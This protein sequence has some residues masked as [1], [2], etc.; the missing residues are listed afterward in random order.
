M[1]TSRIL[2]TASAAAI[3]ATG[4][5]GVSVAKASECAPA[6]VE[7]AFATNTQPMPCISQDLMYVV[8]PVSTSRNRLRPRRSSTQG[9]QIVRRVKSAARSRQAVASAAFRADLPTQPPKIHLA[10][11]KHKSHWGYRSSKGPAKWSTL[12]EKFRLCGVGRQQSPIDIAAA[13]EGTSSSISFD[14][15]GGPATVINNGHTV[16]VNVPRG[17]RLRVGDRVYRLI[18][19]HFHTPSENTIDGLHYPME[20]HLV[21]KDANG[22]LAVIALMVRAGRRGIL[23]N[24]PQPAKTGGQAD[25]GSVNPSDLIPVSKE[26]FVFKGSLTTPPCSEGVDWFVM[27]QPIETDHATIAGLYAILGAN[28]RPTNPLNGRSI[29]LSQ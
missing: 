27:K 29:K 2:I 5:G 23:D 12:D 6:W 9:T 17:N 7:R 8:S 25:A 19:F 16:Q 14:Y 1:T 21:H 24:L 13:A 22:R 18:Q 15:K 10:T 28:N 20:T 26:H 4:V 3:F 11:A